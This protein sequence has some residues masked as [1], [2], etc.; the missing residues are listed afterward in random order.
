MHA[1]RS[2][3]LRDHSTRRQVSRRSAW[4]VARAPLPALVDIRRVSLE[5]CTASIFSYLVQK[6]E[7]TLNRG[8]ETKG[9]AGEN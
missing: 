6:K 1:I 5:N 2:D 4:V 9:L 7:L 8:Y 3:A